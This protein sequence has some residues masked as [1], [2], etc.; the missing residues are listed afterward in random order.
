MKTGL[1]LSLSLI[2]VFACNYEQNRIQTITGL[3]QLSII[4][5]RDTATGMWNQA[6]WMKNGTGYL[7]YDGSGYMSA[8]FLPEGYNEII[9][10][11]DE[12]GLSDYW[13]LAEYSMDEQTQTLTHKRFLHSDPSQRNQSVRRRYEFHGDTLFLFA[14]EFSFRLKWV[15]KQ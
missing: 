11:G 8:H 12:R 14:D 5:V 2:I 9:E 15:K 6:T 3:W 10:T 7:H 13:Y 1:I 4:E